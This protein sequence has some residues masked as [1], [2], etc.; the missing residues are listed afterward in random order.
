MFKNV[1]LNLFNVE[2]VKLI[3]TE[4]AGH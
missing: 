4:Q 3:T 1:T 2:L